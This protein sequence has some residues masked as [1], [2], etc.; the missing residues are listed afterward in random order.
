M[1]VPIEFEAMTVPQRL[2]LIAKIWD[3]IP[4]TDQ[5]LDVP[6]WHLKE[7][8]RRIAAADAD[9]SGV[10]PWEEAKSRLRKQE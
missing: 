1:N 4:E 2:D 3:S 5:A 7:L 10:V 6:E 9:P 8:E